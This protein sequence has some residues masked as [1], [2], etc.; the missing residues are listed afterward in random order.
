MAPALS[1]AMIDNT[2]KLG[3]LCWVLLPPDATAVDCNRD[4]DKSRAIE[5]RDS[6]NETGLQR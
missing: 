3:S 6:M 1:E 2:Y 4:M 5:M